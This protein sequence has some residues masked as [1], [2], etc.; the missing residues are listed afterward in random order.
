MP[1]IYHLVGSDMLEIGWATV[2]L[3]EEVSTGEELTGL[4]ARALRR[5]RAVEEWN[6]V[7]AD[8]TEPGEET[9]AGRNEVKCVP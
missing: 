1:W 9:L 8:V 6:V 3:G 2:F 5:V 7:V 4:A